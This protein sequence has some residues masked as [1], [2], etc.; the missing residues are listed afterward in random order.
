MNATLQCFCHIE[1]LIIFFKYDN[2]ANTLFS[3]DINKLSWSFKLL[4][5]QLW[6]DNYGDPNLKN[7]YEP[8]DFKEKISTMNPLFK[9][10]A[11][12]DAKDL[13]NFIIMTLHEELNKGNKNVNDN[14]NNF[15][16]DQRNQHSMFNNFTKN[17]YDTNNSI[18]SDLF[19]AINCNITQCG[20]C[21]VQTFNYQTY[22]FIVFPLEEVRKFKLS[23]YNNQIMNFNYNNVV[24]IYECFE[25][26]K[27]I[28]I[29]S[30][31]NAMYCNYCKQTCQSSMCT[32]LT[33]GPQILILLLNR[34]KGIEFDVKI[35]FYE[36][37]NLLNY[38]Q[39]NNTGFNYQLIGVITHIGESGM[40]GHF[41]AYCR[42]PI[43]HGWHKYNDSIVTPVNNFQSEVINFAMPYLLF[44]QKM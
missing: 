43:Y 14:N 37:L 4:M 31:A 41:I 17:F 9:G 8:K 15:F 18:I 30:G 39:M 35:N 24:D 42:D 27:K 25:Y 10:V 20:G 22:F 28:N 40:G 29:M 13:V 21:G 23:N 26:D 36:N 34:G 32:L 38:I 1:K 16:I 2:Q 12:N 11:A 3:N 6:P 5:E 7:Y 19:Y 44:Y 33:T